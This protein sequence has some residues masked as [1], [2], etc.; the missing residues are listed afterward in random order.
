MDAAVFFFTGHGDPE[1][2]EKILQ[3]KALM[4]LDPAVSE[5][6]LTYGAIPRNNAEIAILSRSL[7]E[8]IT[9]LCS[10]IEVPPEHVADGRAAK[11]LDEE[12]LPFGF[13]PLFSVKSGTIPTRCVGVRS[14]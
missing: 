4:G 3:A 8:I 14:G 1:I 10:Y 13:P 6:A 2:E 7:L 9:E 5:F 12:Q 11:T